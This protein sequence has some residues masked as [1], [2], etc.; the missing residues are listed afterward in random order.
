MGS[1]RSGDGRLCQHAARVACAAALLASGV[2]GGCRP[3]LPADTVARYGAALERGDYRTAYDQ[4][5]TEY[6]GRVSFE[7]F[8][9]DLAGLPHESRAVGRTLQERARSWGPQA[10]VPV[11]PDERA[12]LRREAGGWRL[13]APPAEP[14]RQDTPR[15][16]LRAFVRAVE[17][18]RWDVLVSLAPGRV[19]DQVTAEKLRRYWTSMGPE[20]T[21][22]FLG[23][24]RLAL[25]RPIMEDEDEAHIVQEDRQIRLV[26]EAGLWRVDSP[27]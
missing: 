8:R 12:V 1:A 4:L 6:R 16:A 22:A 14:Y 5:S 26:R 7:R 3:T 21:R 27:E 11:G 13:L 25:E 17:M 2:A 20:R 10:E 15:A 19:R 23:G 18:G 9:Q 24:L